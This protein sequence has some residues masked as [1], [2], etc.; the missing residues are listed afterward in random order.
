MA[1]NDNRLKEDAY[2][3]FGHWVAQQPYWLQDATYRIY[4][5]IKIADAQ[6]STYAD[7]CVSQA[8]K[9]QAPYLHMNPN[10]SF[11][12]S[13]RGSL[14]ILNISGISCVNALA[15]EACLD[16]SSDGIT[17]VYGLNGAGKSG[18]MRIFKQLSGSPY[19]EIIQPN[20]Y[21]K[22]SI[23]KSK[24]TIKVIEDDQEKE[25]VCD[26]SAG[27]QNTPLSSCDVF[28][29]KIS[30]YYITKNNNVSYQPFVFSVLA[31][32]ASIAGKIAKHI[33]Q[34]LAAIPTFSLA[35]P[36]EFRS[37]DDIEWTKR[38]GPSSVFPVQYTK[39]TNEQQQLINE[40][41][42]K[43]DT[44]NVTSSLN[45]CQSKLK[46]LRPIYQDLVCMEKAIKSDELTTAHKEVCEARRKLD[47]A[48]KLFSEAA[49]KYD[50]ISVTSSE[51]KELWRLAQVYF[52]SIIRADCGGHFGEEGTICPLC[53]RLITDSTAK[54]FKSV[55]DYVNG[56][57]SANYS[58]AVKKYNKVLDAISDRQYSAKQAHD[59]LSGI[60][61]SGEISF[62]EKAYY[63]AEAL[64]S[65]G[66]E[67]KYAF[68]CGIDI[69]EALSLLYK[70]GR[71][72]TTQKNEYEATLK[73]ER[74]ASI[75][76][77]LNDLR[78]HKWAYSIKPLFD[79]EIAKLKERQVLTE[80]K[81][82]L[83]TNKIT[84]ESN[85]LADK[86][87]TGAYLDRFN[88]EMKRLA[89]NIRVKL[90][91]APSQK[92]STPYKVTID[93]DTGI[94]CKPEDILS[95][96]EQ[97]IVALAAFFADAT[98]R[99]A[100][101]PLIIDDP[102][103]SLDMNYE[104]AATKRIVEIAKKRQ[105]V[106]FTHRISMLTGI[107]EAC[108]EQ[109]V[110]HKENYIRSTRK[111]K[112][113]ADLPDVYR[114]RLKNQLSG[115]QTRIKAIKAY[116]P[117]SP[118]YIDS[119]SKQCQQFRICVERSVEEILLLGMVRRFDRRIMTNGKV[120]KL[121]RITDDDCSF[122]DSMMTKYSFSE[123]SQPVDSPQ[124]EIDIDEL[125]EDIG[126]YI[127]W[128]NAFQKRLG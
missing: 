3:Q 105:V 71:E 121:T 75:Q 118:E 35:I 24:C 32:L 55:N 57:C 41:T 111:G 100:N 17:A 79:S 93:T 22:G 7:L 103:S 26:L 87:I 81:A 51:W 10:A 114:G 83:N 128:I 13:S 102:I 19:E 5:G 62:V 70:R 85:R 6:I 89:P 9:D 108:K 97:R 126:N 47:A 109:G 116:D 76:K 45:L 73:D 88:S 43:L 125:N 94:K 2:T 115:I 23:G 127:K 15:K 91:K 112:G 107:E 82:F 66:F 56:T 113:V 104:T 38:I 20:V 12:H 92:G 46:V 4:H 36:E 65:L 64:Q 80:A 67:E 69:S 123:H 33:D 42:K 78:F 48:A 29:T 27:P 39:W 16:F 122:V 37:R 21:E 86:L 101:T 63:S 1:Y 25:L 52:D 30:N 59:L 72:L 44:D 120:E 53:H 98:G 58:K 110:P 95:E 54:R 50:R 90:D 34:R 11:Y 18:F 8:K 96:G 106:V 74:R 119:V 14:S 31:E 28:D 117:D 60:I 40:K 49:D 61:D 84:I 77:Q 99:E 124:V 68:V